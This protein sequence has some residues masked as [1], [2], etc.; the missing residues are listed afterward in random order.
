MTLKSIIKRLWRER[1]IIAALVTAVGSELVTHID[2]PEF[3]W[4][5]AVII[6]VGVILRFFTT[7]W[8]IDD[9]AKELQNK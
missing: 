7:P 8:P 3:R 4:S 9:K 1:T 5:Q 6:A 2:D